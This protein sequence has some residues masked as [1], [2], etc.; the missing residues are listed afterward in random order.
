MS[1]DR[2]PDVDAYIAKAED[3]AKPIL[4]HLRKVVH[5]ACPDVEE[6]MR[7]SFPHFD[8]RGMMLSMASFKEHCTFNFWKQSIMNDPEKL[9]GSSGEAMGSFGRIAKKSDLPSNKILKSYI[10]EAMRLN[11]EGISVPKKK[12]KAAKKV[13]VPDY[14]AAEL[15]KYRKA[16]KT[17][18]NFSPSHKR[19]YIEWITEA[20]R[21]NTR[22]KRMAQAIEWLSEGKSRNWKYQK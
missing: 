22:Q 7:W 5:E 1:K 12:P 3:F 9:F 8:H 20:K 17:F 11:E 4:E 10:K 2:S 18:E 19:E 13:D 21:E 6:K 16:K 15:D 14:F